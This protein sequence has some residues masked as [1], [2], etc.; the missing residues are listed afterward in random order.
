VRATHILIALGSQFASCFGRAKS[1]V[2][3]RMNWKQEVGLLLSEITNSLAEWFID[4]GVIDR[5]Q[6]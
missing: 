4:A 2:F 1:V 5:E 3:A 6:Q